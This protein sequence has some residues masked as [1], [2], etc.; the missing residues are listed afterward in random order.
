M[1]SIDL[2]IKDKSK[3][4]PILSHAR[5]LI[6]RA[7]V[8]GDVVVRL[9]RPNKSREQEEKYHAMINDI[10][11]T[12]GMP[13][14]DAVGN[15]LPGFVTKYDS[16]FWKAVLVDGF[17]QELKEQG[18]NLRK[19]SRIVRSLD[20]ERWVSLRA[21]TKDFGKQHASMFIEYLYQIGTE[22][23]ATFSEKALAY[24]DEVKK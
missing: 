6:E 14:Y 16:E 19:P 24:Y 15:V 23:G 9:C 11:K 21:S 4:E 8:A 20:R 17:E 3:I 7:I 1:A 12:V 22:L 13:V 10:A 2:I 18:I 5:G